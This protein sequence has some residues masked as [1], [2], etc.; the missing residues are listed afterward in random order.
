M[1]IDTTLDIH[2]VD[3]MPELDI[4]KIYTSEKAMV[5]FTSIWLVLGLMA[6]GY[7]WMYCDKKLPIIS[8]VLQFLLA[9]LIGPF[10]IIYLIGK[11]KCE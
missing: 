10:Y 3:D 2:Y 9:L 6:F 8:R 7:S 4:K 1:S 11:R 5:T